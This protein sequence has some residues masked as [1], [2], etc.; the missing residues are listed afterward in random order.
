MLAAFASRDG[1]FVSQHFG[2]TPFF[3]IVEINEDTFQWHVVEQRLNEPPCEFGVHNENALHKS[4]QLISDCDVLF[5]AMVGE[6]AR[7]E[8][9]RRGIQTL[10]LTGFIDEILEWYI[11]YILKRS[12]SDH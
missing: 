3:C 2:H 1:K 11:S 8:L 4:I 9:E 5:V 7:N 6:H 12:E 10:E